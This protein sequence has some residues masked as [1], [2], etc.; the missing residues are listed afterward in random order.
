MKVI[1]LDI[2]GVMNSQIFYKE[3]YKRTYWRRLGNRIISKI[4]FA[5]N[6]FKHK[7]L[8]EYTPSKDWGTAKYLIKRLKEETC[9]MKWEWLSE[10]CN[11]EGYKI[12]ISSVWKNSL[13][14]CNDWEIVLQALGFKEGT[15]IGITQNRRTLR[16]QEIQEVIDKH[17]ITEYAII[18]DDSD[19]LEHQ[20]I[21]FFHSDGWY[22]LTPGMIYRIK[23]HFNKEYMYAHL[24]EQIKMSYGHIENKQI[25]IKNN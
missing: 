5:L 20:F 17:N 18:D 11:E 15:S 7:T 22:G 9:S 24:N 6:G 14:N 13:N 12:C 2:D 23:K 1:F 8:S 25:P 4:K 16:G 21:N 10:V 3:R 19:M